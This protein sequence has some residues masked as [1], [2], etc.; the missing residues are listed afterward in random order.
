LECVGY[1]GR[2]VN[3]YLWLPGQHVRGEDKEMK[4]QGLRQILGSGKVPVK[5]DEA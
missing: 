1:S 4:C 3:M 2:L 5:V